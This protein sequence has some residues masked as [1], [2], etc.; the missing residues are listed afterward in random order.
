[1]RLIIN[2]TACC[3][4]YLTI[5]FRTRGWTGCDPAGLPGWHFARKFCLETLSFSANSIKRFQGKNDGY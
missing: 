1:M 5:C 3:C 4:E 2:H